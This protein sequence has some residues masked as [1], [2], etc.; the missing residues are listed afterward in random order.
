MSKRKPND[1]F[2]RFAS[3]L[4]KCCQKFAVN[5]ARTA[6]VTFVCTDAAL[7][8]AMIATRGDIPVARDLVVSAM[9]RH[10]VL[11]SKTSKKKK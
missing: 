2:N 4:Y 1:P 3:D 5:D 7:T 10:L 8:A 6:F 11:K 9:N